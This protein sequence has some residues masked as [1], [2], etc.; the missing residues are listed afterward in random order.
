MRHYGFDNLLNCEIAGRT[1]AK[2]Y[3]DN[4][5]NFKKYYEENKESVLKR[6]SD[7][8]KNNKDKIKANKSR[9]WTCVICDIKIKANS[10]SRHLK[11][12]THIKK[13]QLIIKT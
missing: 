8:Q 6:V 3:L 10:K 5:D 1:L 7:Y 2:Y 11:G 4:K 13:A 12:P 9:P